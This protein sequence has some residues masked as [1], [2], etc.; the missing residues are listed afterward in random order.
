MQNKRPGSLLGWDGELELWSALETRVCVFQE[1]C[2]AIVVKDVRKDKGT[3]PKE[4]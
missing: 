3:V 4:L 2:A 1:S